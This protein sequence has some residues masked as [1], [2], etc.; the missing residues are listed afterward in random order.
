MALNLFNPLKS[1]SSARL[2]LTAFVITVTLSCLLEI[3]LFNHDRWTTPDFPTETV[4]LP[5]QEKY[6]LKAAVITAENPTV[7]L[8][9]ISRDIASVEICTKGSPRVVTGHV[10]LADDANPR[11]FMPAADFTVNPGGNAACA[12]AVLDPRGKVRALGIQFENP[13][14]GELL[15]TALTLNPV[16]ALSISATRTVLTFAALFLVLCTVFFKPW[17]TPYTEANR[18]HRLLSYGVLALTLAFCTA[19]FCLQGPFAPQQ[20]RAFTFLSGSQLV[21]TTDESNI[22]Q[23]VPDHA[24]LAVSDPYVQLYDAFTHGRTW[25][26]LDV[27]PKLAALENP[28]DTSVRA[29]EKVDY[30]WDRAY[31]KGHYYS[32]FG[33]APL[34]TAYLPVK[35]LTG[36]LPLPVLAAY[37][38]AVL[39]ALAVFTA[40]GTLMRYY[41]LQASLFTT[42]ITQGA[43]LFAALIP[44]L[45]VSVTFYY[46]PYLS[47][48]LWLALF[49][50]TMYKAAL[51]E[52]CVRRRLLL[53][54][55]GISVVLLVLSR[56]LCV[57]FV[58]LF[59][60]DPAFRLFKMYR[61]NLRVL[62][63]DFIAI[64][65]PV[66]LGAV[67]VCTYNY[68]RFENIFEFGQFLQLT[69]T[70]IS[71]NEQ[72]L[73]VKRFMGMLWAFYL[74]P[75][76]VAA[77]FPFYSLVHNAAP[78]VGNYIYTAPHAGLL[79]FIFY[80]G[81]AL[82]IAEFRQ[83]NRNLAW[84]TAACIALSLVMSYFAFN[85]AGILIRYICDS[86]VPLGLTAGLLIL[87]HAG[88]HKNENT[89]VAFWMVSALLLLSIL[90]SGLLVFADE[91]HMMNYF[92]PDAVVHLKRSFNLF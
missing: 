70:D 35:L 32:Y 92:N 56:P 53:A 21:L 54:A 12:R 25:L 59:F 48:Y 27:D 57:L 49:I 67:A 64:A 29:A 31:Y 2:T 80:W 51:T 9:N 50:S 10:L 82:A 4:E 45:Q 52:S 11:R 78:G 17:L 72:V 55:A 69:V 19:L 7:S 24:A 76:G 62:A 43:L 14:Q 81:L 75:L 26:D 36:K 68:V 16:P 33:P 89:A 86:T 18:S 44:L 1:G 6:G 8:Q 38:S 3:F 85:N 73:S 71:Q 66:A 74:E 61:S 39:A 23:P 60:A 79:S 87:K 46:L 30:F 28:Y 47:A 37:I 22:L 34:L 65:V 77:A 83:K 5:L 40:F 63:K 13:G 58:V 84:L 91:N 41:K 15:L 88:T 90:T 42:L 20:T